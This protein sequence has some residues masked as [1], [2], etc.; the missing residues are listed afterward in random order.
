MLLKRKCATNGT[1]ISVYSVILVY[2][3]AYFYYT[4][5]RENV[6]VV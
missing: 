6:L 2:A 4:N 5:Q 3:V 1:G